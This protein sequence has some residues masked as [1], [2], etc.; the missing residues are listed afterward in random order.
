MTTTFDL[1]QL[2]ETALQLAALGIPVCPLHTPDEQGVCDC[3]KRAECEAPGKHPRTLH[4][5]DDATTSEKKIRTWWK[6]WPHANIAIDLAGASLVDIAPDSVDWHG[7]FIARGLPPTLTF[8]SGGGDGHMHYLYRCSDACPVYR[9]TV[10]GQYDVLSA[11]YAVVPPSLHQSG[12]RYAWT[13]AGPLALPDAVEPAWARDMLQARQNR[14][15]ERAQSTLPDPDGPPVVLRGDAL[16]RWHGRVCDYRPDGDV[17]RSYSLWSLA[18]ALLAGG[19]QPH[20]VEDA[21]AERDVNLGWTKFSNRGDATERYRIIVARAVASQG[22]RRIQLNGAVTIDTPPRH[23]QQLPLKWQTIGEFY[24]N[25]SPDVNWTAVGFIGDGLITEIDGKAKS[26]GK[27]QLLLALAYAVLHHQPFLGQPTTYTP[28]VYLTEQSGPSF[29]RS[30][31]RSG[32]EPEDAF[33]LLCWADTR[34]WLWPQI[35]EGALAK[36]DELG[37]HLL[38]VDTLPQFS[39]VRGDDENRSGAAL[40]VMEPLQ[41]AMVR[42]LGIMISRHDRKSGGEVGDSGR[43]SSAYTGAADIMIHLTRPD[44]KP[45]NDRQRVLTTTGRFPEETPEQLLIELT[46]D[47]PQHYRVLGDPE[48]IKTRNLRADLLACLPITEDEAVTQKE[49]KLMI[50]GD[51]A[52]IAHELNRL[53]HEG[54]VMRIGRGVT[55]D[56]FRYHQRAWADD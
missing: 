13:E 52:K 43:G 23:K 10:T 44:A 19:L 55:G 34:G 7:E 26:S 41:A 53:V 2:R 48:E 9:L 15:Q 12:R 5:L 56:P 18:V 17:D 25:Q 37:S 3:P 28:V 4:G 39:G 33:T 14:R 40:E 11:G 36:V 30:L 8:S 31:E 46:T 49:M 6:S 45:G 29:R 54:V 35:V 50:Q 22:P 27:T 32:L 16:E 21:L 20:L 51:W 24:A 38:I 47:R 42:P 1:A